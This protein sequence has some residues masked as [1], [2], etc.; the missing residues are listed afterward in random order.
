MQ[1]CRQPLERLLSGRWKYVGSI[2][3]SLSVTLGFYKC[4]FGFVAGSV[5]WLTWSAGPEYAREEL[6]LPLLKLAG[7]RSV[8]SSA[9]DEAGR[10]APGSGSD[11]FFDCCSS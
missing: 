7:M 4:R 10:A 8:H 11:F 6:E 1:K 5:I 9:T 3:I 2:T